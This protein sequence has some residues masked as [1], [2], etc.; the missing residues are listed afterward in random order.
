M[1]APT[2]LPDVT[3]NDTCNGLIFND[4]TVYSAGTILSSTV[5]TVTLKLAYSSLGTYIQYVFTVVNNVITECTL[6]L[7]G[8]TPV[9][10]TSELASTVFPLVDFDLTADYGVTIPTSEDGVY[11]TTYRVQGTSGGQP[12]NYSGTQQVLI[13][14]AACC[15]ISKMFQ[16]LNPENCCD[17]KKWMTAMRAASYLSASRYATQGGFVDNAVAALNMAQSICDN[18]CGCN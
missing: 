5:T 15:C 10:I 4:N 8:D 3:V 11:Y 17:D 7:A 2:I 1:A 16:E 14:C 6:S 9:V 12:Y 13:E 18:G